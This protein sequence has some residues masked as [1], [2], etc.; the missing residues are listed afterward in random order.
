MVRNEDYWK[1]GADGQPLPYMDGIGIASMDDPTVVETAYRNGEI[2]VGGFPLSSLQ[3]ESIGAD[4]PDH[5]QGQIAFGFT[6]ITGIFN[7]NP[8]WPGEDGLGNPYLDRRFCYALH[9]AVDRYLMIDAV[10]LGS[11][12]PSGQEHTPWFNNTGRF[13]KRNCSRLRVTAPTEMPTS[14]TRGRPWMPRD[15]TRIAR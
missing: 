9:L 1:M 13:Q 15:T 5:P 14:P 11:G 4:F 2:D 7:Y 10:Y 12:K 6:I 3:A 8:D